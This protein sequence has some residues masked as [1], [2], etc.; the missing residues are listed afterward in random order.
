MLAQPT[1]W[2]LERFYPHPCAVAEKAQTLRFHQTGT[3]S[4]HMSEQGAVSV[5]CVPV[6]DWVEKASFMKFDVEG[7][8][9]RALRGSQRLLQQ[10][11]PRLAIAAYH[12]ATD[13][14]DIAQTLDDLAPGYTL[15]LRHHLGYHFDTILYATPRKDWHPIDTAA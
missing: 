9:S 13:I 15:Y 2:P 14:L 4:S 5:Q 12:Y 10:H 3:V 11:R 1:P 8:E 7:F 6:D